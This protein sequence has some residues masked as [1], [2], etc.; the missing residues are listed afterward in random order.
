MKKLLRLVS[1]LICMCMFLEGQ[2]TTQWE[3]I[4]SG[5]FEGLAEKNGTV[6]IPPVYEAIGWSDGGQ[7][8][9]SH[10]IGYKVGAYWGLISIKNK[11]IT[12]PK[13]TILL[14]DSPRIKG[15]VKGKFSNQLFYGLM[16]GRGEVTVSFNYF[17]IDQLSSQFLKVSE[18]K[19]RTPQYGVLSSTGDRVLSCDFGDVEILGDM[20]VGEKQ[21]KKKLFTTEGQ[22]VLDMWLDD[23]TLTDQGYLLYNEG[24]YGLVSLDGTLHHEVVYK[25][26][27]AGGAR[28]FNQWR[29]HEMKT[30]VDKEVSCDSL[31]RSNEGFWI[32]H[33][34]E[35]PHLLSPS[36]VPFL[37][38]NNK[39][40]VRIHGAFLLMQDRSDLKWSVYKDDGTAFITAMDS[41]LL[42]GQF[43][44]TK[45]RSGWDVYNQFGRKLNE[46]TCE[47]VLGEQSGYIG[48]K[49]SG[50]WGW[51][52]FNGEQ[53]VKC[54]Y[55]AIEL[56]ISK[57]SYIIKYVDEWGVADF[58]D[59]FVIAP[60]YDRI[61]KIGGLY[62]A[63]TGYAKRIFTQEG[64][65][66]YF[67]S[68]PVSGESTLL[69]GTKDSLGAVL[70]NG[71]V[72]D[73]DFAQIEAQKGFYKLSKDTHIALVNGEGDYVIRI[74]DQIQNVW[75]Q[76]ED[77]FLIKKNGGYG[78]VDEQGRLRIA[79]RYDEAK[80]FCEGLAA[81]KL[82]GKWGFLNK[83]ERLV[84]QPFYDE[85]G[86][87]Q[88]GLAIVKR[89]KYYGIVD[90]QG[91]EVV[92]IKWK[93]IE[94][95][96]SG[97]FVV[98]DSEG[99]YGLVDKQGGS[100]YA[101]IFEYL[102]DT[103]VGL[104]I[105]QKAEKKGVMTFEGFTKYPFVYKKIRS[106]DE[107]LLFLK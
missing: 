5:R 71:K 44:F 30:G 86:P 54:K 59:H 34:N 79:N 67:T 49:R 23:I 87:F 102:E 16:D 15:A 76:A 57:D 53:L 29:I 92:D 3:V 94:R 105:A 47:E 36:S 58:N 93:S 55:D 20:I 60:E 84:V 104:V 51:L 82:I 66:V 107:Y 65:Q 7:E 100:I 42:S 75:P 48:V 50:Y 88:D 90:K 12:P 40:L 28:S 83:E 25:G 9:L 14:P 1:V 43:I 61:E 89:G 31:T 22:P 56:G 63:H 91:E 11:K 35:I 33:F 8:V 85:V 17:S 72:I 27:D 52:D 77:W 26:I 64:K 80:S 32:A 98:M 6:V 2:A 103:G 4:K 21:N 46:Y 81:V 41:I 106:L 101:P 68:S 45:D 73:Q 39:T 13:F 74:S 95:Q 38:N 19:N 62:V 37:E 70:P 99:N 10:A 24:K 69:L 78:F 96:K 97:N 18:Y